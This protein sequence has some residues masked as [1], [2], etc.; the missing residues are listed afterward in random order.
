MP[1]AGRR[2]HHA[3]ELPP[4]LAETAACPQRFRRC[5]PAGTSTRRPPAAR[6][7]SRSRSSSAS[8]PRSS[9]PP[10]RAGGSS[11][12][13]ARPAGRACLAWASSR[14]S[15]R[16]RGTGRG[17]AS[18]PARP[19]LRGAEERRAH[20]GDA[21]RARAL[22]VGA[23]LERRHRRAGLQVL[24]FAPAARPDRHADGLVAGQDLL[25]LSMT[26]GAPPGGD[27][28]ARNGF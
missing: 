12:E 5:A 7:A 10:T 14:S 1:D 6:C 20:R 25:R 15:R 24:A 23:D 3:H 4:I 26:T 28:A 21:G 16:A 8:S 2:P 11:G 18:Q 17:R 9:P 13:S 22:Q 27:P 19:R